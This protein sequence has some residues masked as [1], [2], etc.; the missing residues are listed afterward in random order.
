MGYEPTLTNKV[1]WKPTSVKSPQDYVYM[2]YYILKDI[3]IRK[4]ILQEFPK[5]NIVH[6]YSYWRSCKECSYDL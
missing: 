2:C 6:S 1:M 5:M 4:Y 3:D